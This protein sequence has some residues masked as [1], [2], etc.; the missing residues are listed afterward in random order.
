M[1]YGWNMRPMVFSNITTATN[2]QKKKHFL[3]FFYLGNFFEHHLYAHAPI[4]SFST[5]PFILPSPGLI[6]KNLSLLFRSPHLNSLSSLVLTLIRKAGCH[7]RT[8]PWQRHWTGRLQGPWRTKP[9]KCSGTDA[10]LPPSVSAASQRP[11][12]NP[13][14]NT[15]THTHS[16]AALNTSHK[17]LLQVSAELGQF[18]YFTGKFTICVTATQQKKR[19]LLYCAIL[20]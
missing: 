3:Q 20:F 12:L 4:T 16:A 2:K 11:P 9:G 10:N 19:K 7:R 13:P 5:C 18:S 17:L 1:C 8:G 6:K 15:H 14:A